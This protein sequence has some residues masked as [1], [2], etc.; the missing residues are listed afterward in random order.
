MFI[1]SPTRMWLY[2]VLTVACA[3]VQAQEPVTYQGADTI[4]S[5]VSP[6][7]INIDPASL[8]AP[9]PWQ[10]GD[11]VKDIPLQFDKNFNPPPR[12]PRPVGL[13]PLAE[14]Q[15]EASEQRGG[16]DPD[17]G[18]L[19]INV[20]GSPFTGSSPSDTVGD[21][22]NNFYVQ[23]VN[24]GGA[25][26]S[27]VLIFD[28]T[29]GSMTMSFAL[30]SLAAGS[31]TGCVSG[32]GDPIINFDETADNGPGEMPGKWILT[33][34]TPMGV[35]TVCVYISETSD[36]TAGNW[37]LYEFSSTTGGFPDYPK[38]GVWSDAIYL[39]VNELGAT[40]QQ[41]ALDRE[42]MIQG[43]PARPLQAF[44]SA[45]QL[46]GFG[47]QHIMPIDWD[48]DVPP[49]PGSPGLFMR[50]RDTEIHGPAG[51]PDADII[52]LWEFSVDF[53]NAANSS[54]TGPINISIS[55]F[56]SEFCNLV[57]S[58]CLVQPNS[59][60]TLF[61]LLQPIM[62]RG[63]YRNFGSHQSIVANMV[64][65]VTGTDVG[66][67]RW[68]ELRN[69]GGGYTTFQDG[70]ITEP[71]TVNGT[72]GISRWMASA[73]Q[74]EAGN[75]AV[76]YNVVGV[77]DTGTGDDV[78]PGMRYNGRLASDPL[79]TT[80][81]G[82]VSIMEGSA[83][84]NSIRYGD[85]SALTVD[86]IDG[87]QFWYTAQHNPAANYSTQIASFRFS[88]CGEP[89][90]TL[91]ADNSIQQVCAPDDLADININ[92]GSVSD[93]LNPVTL[94]LDS[95]PA[96]FTAGFT[97]NPVVPGNSTVAQISVSGAAAPGDNILTILGTATGAD[98]RTATILAEVFNAT[99]GAPGLQLPADGATDVSLV[100]ILEWTEGSQPGSYF[101]EIATDS[102]FN[103]V[104]YN[105]MENGTVHQ[106]GAA[107]NSLTGYFWRVTPN[108]P[109]GDGAASTTFSFTTRELPPILL[110]DDDDN[111]PDVQS[112]YV[113]ALNNLGIA[114]DL[115]DTNNTDNEPGTEILAYDAV[116][117][118]SGDEFGG[119]AGPGATAEGILGNFL[120]SP[121]KC[122]LLS[123]QDYFF[124]RGLTP[125]MSTYLGI[126]G[127]TNDSG[128]Y[129]SVSGAGSS[130]AGLGPY[131]LDYGTPGLQDFSDIL[132]IGGSGEL[133][134]DGNNGNDA[135][136]ADTG[137]NS[138]FL[139][140]PLA[141]VSGAANR[142]E[143]L[144]AFI[145]NNC[146]SFSVIEEFFID[147]F[148]GPAPAR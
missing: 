138:V 115:F 107:L 83:P 74:D 19:I 81:Q 17:F 26:G 118:F 121:N 31:G 8:T 73:A 125:F 50:H 98:D 66:G 48:G 46:P 120:E 63:Q 51:M 21:V 135:G 42:N 75:I 88:A 90:F 41:Y 79:G 132:A 52:E 84:N 78:F 127:A 80:P 58:G 133:S 59:G 119:V 71:G 12:E 45:P 86:P 148:E 145:D 129:T 96:G 28:K 104:V 103:N 76:G 94:S 97:V 35:D 24:G 4:G 92:V 57:F 85:Y 101:V 47:F 53:D 130:F 113:D 89:G 13:D 64:T 32:A 144:Q 111:T 123:S 147:G 67:V 95:P 14:R 109:C 105:A 37:F 3:T 99:P 7:I 20:P 38:Y 140:F 114:F 49:P 106:V 30:E 22:G 87:C 128:D 16:T 36:P 40:P 9:R 56:D 43:L 70:T 15:F 18:N 91:S 34:F 102:N 69:T 93:F 25:A 54:L 122:L 1:P 100:P 112:I 141:A 5:A 116:I 136:S 6:V 2:A 108:N 137:F 77:G 134:F 39:G 29:D 68:F 23:A 11:P 60:T 62:W 82:E 117:W 139:G 124:D 44:G 33:E 10:P 142:E 110:V 55:E 143:I 126:T 146:G 72:D 27:N 65:D 131:T 61:A